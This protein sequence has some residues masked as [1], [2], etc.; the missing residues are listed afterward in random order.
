MTRVG[1]R[2][3]ERRETGG[4]EQGLE[5]IELEGQ[6]S[7]DYTQSERKSWRSLARSIEP[8][9]ASASASGTVPGRALY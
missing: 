8:S 9:A 5:G 2:G 7:G 4:R 3:R 1:R 6:T